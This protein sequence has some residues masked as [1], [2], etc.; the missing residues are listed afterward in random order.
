MA[1]EYQAAT[2]WQSGHL[3][4]DLEGAAEIDRRGDAQALQRGGFR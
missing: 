3:A 1:G 2:S 4:V